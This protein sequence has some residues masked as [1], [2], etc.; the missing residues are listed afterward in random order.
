MHRRTPSPKRVGPHAARAV[1]CRI[2]SQFA[3]ALFEQSAASQSPRDG[4]AG[5]R[6]R[7]RASRA[8]AEA[9]RQQCPYSLT[10]NCESESDGQASADTSRVA[11]VLARPHC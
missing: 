11:T 8:A 6:L 5:D 1:S 4:L 10:V 3:K 9:P 7:S 2:A